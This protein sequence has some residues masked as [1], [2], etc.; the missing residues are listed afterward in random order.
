MD[1]S[2]LLKRFAANRAGASAAL[3]REAARKKERDARAAVQAEAAERQYQQ[4]KVDKRL[5][6][7]KRKAAEERRRASK[8]RGTAGEK[9]K[10]A[11]IAEKRKDE[12]RMLK[13]RK[14]REA[15]AAAAARGDMPKILPGYEYVQQRKKAKQ[16]VVVDA[17]DYTDLYP[18]STGLELEGDDVEGKKKRR[19]EAE[20][21][22]R[23]IEKEKE[24][25]LKQYNENV[26]KDLADGGRR[27]A[28]SRWVAIDA[29]QAGRI[30]SA[31]RNE[32]L[33]RSGKPILGLG[34]SAPSSSRSTGAASSS[35]ASLP[36]M[37]KEEAAKSK[38][39]DTESK[40]AS[41]FG[42]ICK[43]N[44]RTG[45]SISMPPPK[46][47]SRRSGSGKASL[48]TAKGRVAKSSAKGKRLGAPSSSS[49][50]V[51]RRRERDE[52]RRRDRDAG[53]RGR[54]DRDRRGR[55]DRDGGRGRYGDVYSD[56]GDGYDDEYVDD[57]DD[58]D[59]GNFGSSF[60]DVQD[61]EMEAER[62]A[63]LEDK[64]E[65]KREA[66]HKEEKLRLKKEWAKKNKTS[67]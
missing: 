59:D 38:A 23:E 1:A 30:A 42:L 2:S 28:E 50:S 12:D 43:A 24:M 56:G 3:E 57:D 4:D 51:G 14:R 36:P 58:D 26:I 47:P 62:L 25:E 6:V 7:T 49:P 10:R 18:E 41:L 32:Q 48:S 9:A 66:R 61:E 55:D 67:K 20:K 17:Q 53:G 40:A 60:A 8:M 19:A 21:K 52:P 45:S 31:K 5:G 15:G 44:G 11:A 37:T 22:N 16:V 54:N 13:I 29:G 39:A 35:R 64:R 63:K 46:S 33:T 65:S 34:S 27:I